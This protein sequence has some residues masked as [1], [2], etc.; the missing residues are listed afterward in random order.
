M[1]LLDSTFGLPSI[2]NTLNTSVASV[3][4]SAINFAMAPVNS[5]IT[6]SLNSVKSTFGN[7]APDFSK[8]FGLTGAGGAASATATDI[9]SAI[10]GGTDTPYRVDISGVSVPTHKVTLKTTD[11]AGKEE[12]VVFDIMPEVSETRTVGYENLSTPHMP[13]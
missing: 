7:I 4:S 11:S 1:G 8:M 3:E 9:K 13:G 12:I 10:S 5:V 6:E 2:Q